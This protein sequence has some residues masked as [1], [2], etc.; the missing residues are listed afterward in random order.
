MSPEPRL[1]KEALRPVL[2]INF[3][4]NSITQTFFARK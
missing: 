4:D 1:Q 3:F 2:L